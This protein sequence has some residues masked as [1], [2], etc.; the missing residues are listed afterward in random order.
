MKPSA[1]VIAAVL[2]ACPVMAVAQQRLPAEDVEAVNK[3]MKER[4]A[5]EAGKPLSQPL[6]V[7]DNGLSETSPKSPTPAP[8][9]TPPRHQP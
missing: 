4:Y 1:V 3:I 8:S 5:K 9:P 6:P 7:S 2:A